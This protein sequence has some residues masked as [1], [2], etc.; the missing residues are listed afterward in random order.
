[1]LGRVVL[2][3]IISVQNDVAFRILNR[4]GFGGGL[5][6]VVHLVSAASHAGKIDVQGFVGADVVKPRAE[7]LVF[8]AVYF[9]YA[10]GAAVVF[11]VK[12]QTQL[13]VQSENGAVNVYRK[14][15]ERGVGEREIF[16]YE[17]ADKFAE[18]RVE[19]ADGVSVF[20]CVD[21]KVD[22]RVDR[23]EAIVDRISNGE[24]GHVEIR[25]HAEVE[26]ACA[27]T[28]GQIVIWSVVFGNVGT[29]VLK[30]DAEVHALEK[31]VFYDCVDGKAHLNVAGD[32][33]QNSVQI[34]SESKLQ[35]IADVGEGVAE[36]ARNDA[37]NRRQQA[38]K[39]SQRNVKM[40]FAG[41]GGG[42]LSG[43][44]I[45]SGKLFDGFQNGIAQNAGNHALNRTRNVA[46]KAADKFSEAVLLQKACEIELVKQFL[47]RGS[48]PFEVHI[49]ALEN[50]NAVGRTHR[51]RDV[52]GVDI[53]VAVDF[54]ETHQNL[55]RAVF[56]NQTNVE[57]EFA[58]LLVLDVQR[59]F[60][61]KVY[62]FSGVFVFQEQKAAHREVHV[63]AS[64]VALFFGFGYGVE[65]HLHRK[66]VV[67]ALRRADDVV[68]LW[69]V[70]RLVVSAGR[71]LVSAVRS[72]VGTAGCKN[73]QQNADDNQNQNQ[74]GK[75]NPLFHK[76]AS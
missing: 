34:P 5:N 15:A 49:V 59:R 58:V 31:V 13:D 53:E 71:S 72:V 17:A 40:L 52:T 66:A 38:V 16:A 28:R 68:V 44:H 46:Q 75:V 24:I 18:T 67:D 35:K 8:C 76:L 20:F 48:A 21:L 56:V 57:A 30:L 61:V 69:P 26:V 22:V 50:V 4:N 45:E 39:L 70:V 74:L 55:F 73:R 43:G 37:H 6:I 23:R 51:S 29:V 36:K 19:G 60:H 1:M 47:S 64:D 41:F 54:V 42:Q 25:L 12:F 10:V 2:N 7:L 32:S 33:F 11:E 62:V 14:V 9:H 65:N 27:E 63:F 3:V